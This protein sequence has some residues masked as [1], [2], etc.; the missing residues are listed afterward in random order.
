MPSSRQATITRSAISP[1]FAIRIFL[2]IR[3]FDREQALAVLNRLA[4]LDVALHDLSIALRVDLVH[5]LHRFDDAEDLPLA[6]RRSDVR[7][8][9]RARLGRAVEGADDRRLYN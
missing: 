1:R 9:F 7:E 8:R 3:R 6:H 5:Q 2:N 4:V